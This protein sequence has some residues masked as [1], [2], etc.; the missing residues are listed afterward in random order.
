MEEKGCIRLQIESVFPGYFCYLVLNASGNE[1]DNIPPCVLCPIYRSTT[2]SS[3]TCGGFERLTA[4]P[5]GSIELLAMLKPPDH[6][7]I[8]P[9]K[10]EVLLYE[11]GALCSN[12]LG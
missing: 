7:P 3:P 5:P 12:L 9:Q 11:A 6:Q 10:A 4:T 8:D 1:V 2:L